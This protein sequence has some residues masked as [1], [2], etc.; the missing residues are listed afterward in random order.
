MAGHPLRSATR[1][2]LGGPSPRQLADRTRVTPQAGFRHFHLPAYGVLASVSKRY[3]PPADMS[4]RVT[5]PSATISTF[6]RTFQCQPSDLHV[7][8]TP[9]AFVLS[10]DQTLHGYSTRFLRCSLVLRLSRCW[11]E[12]MPCC[13]TPSS[14]GKGHNTTPRG[15]CQH[16][17]VDLQE[18]APQ[19]CIGHLLTKRPGFPKWPVMPSY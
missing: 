13:R 18:A 4:S 15:S 10:Q 19:S 11:C 5:H 17:P 8:S 12:M 16:L 2:R 14:R 9:P 1:H 7:L 6:Q 3:P